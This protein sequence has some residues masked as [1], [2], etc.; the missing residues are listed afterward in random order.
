MWRNRRRLAVVLTLIV[1][2]VLI[3]S[4]VYLLHETPAQQR[5][6]PYCQWLQNLSE[7]AQPAILVVVTPLVGQACLELASVS[8]Q[9]PHHLPFS[10]R[11]PPNR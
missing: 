1:S 9:T 5:T 8:S 3:S 2:F 7:G 11:A 4:H 6:C 10:A